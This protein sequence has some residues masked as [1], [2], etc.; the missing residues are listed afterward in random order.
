MNEEFLQF[1]QNSGQTIFIEAEAKSGRMENF[2]IDYNARYGHEIDLGTDGICLLGDDVDKWGIELRIYVNNI[3]NIPDSWSS[4]N[5]RT[6]HY[7]SN[8]FAYR[9]DDNSLVQF[10]FENGYRIGRN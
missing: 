3:I 2:I 6:T 8:E 4:K 7:R 1:L 10:L 9:L 5:Y